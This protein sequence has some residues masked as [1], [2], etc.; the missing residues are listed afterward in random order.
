MNKLTKLTDNVSNILIFITMI[1]MILGNSKLLVDHGIES[2]VEYFGY[3]LLMLGVIYTFITSN[4]IKDIKKWKKT[5]IMILVVGFLFSFGIM[6]QGLSFGTKIRLVAT[7]GV[8][9]IIPF[10]ADN[11]M[12]TFEKIRSASY[13]ILAGTVITTIL[14][15]IG[16]SKVLETSYEGVLSIGFRGGV[17]FKNF[18]AADILASFMGIFFYYRYRD[19]Y[20]NIKIKRMDLIVM[21]IEGI[22]IF[23]SSSRGGYLLFIIFLL[24]TLYEKCK[25]IEIKK[26]YICEIIAGILMVIG[27]IIAF[28]FILPKSSNYMYRIRG[29]ENYFKY[30]KG[31]WFHLIF[32]NSQMA[33]GDSRYT[34]IVNIRRH[35]G[36]NG[37]YEM[38]FINTLIKNGILGIAGFVIIFAHYIR[39]I[40]KCSNWR[41]KTASLSVVSVLLFSSMVESYVCNIHAFFGV[42]SYL[43]MCGI[44]GMIKKEEEK[45]DLKS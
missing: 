2:Y 7:M 21:C 43:V 36:W 5:I 3:A 20:R 44:S 32:G 16:G 14:A 35:V 24:S 26:L 12:N 23:L 17:E 11:Y 37:S 28:K 31:D 6:I 41:L 10:A 29:I 9:A 39:Q 18:Y 8:L 4:P 27:L 45:H 38:G 25:S 42:Y 22:L 13:G 40:F 30:L 34:Y 1:I 15:L 33:F 19:S